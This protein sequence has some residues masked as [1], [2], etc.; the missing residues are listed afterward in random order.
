YFYA[1]SQSALFDLG[2]KILLG[3]FFG[4]ALR[5]GGSRAPWV[6]ALGLGTILEAAQ[7]LQRSHVPSTTDVLSMTVGAA[8]GA[9][10]LERYRPGTAAV[11]GPTATVSDFGH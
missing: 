2:K 1:S 4:A 11:S 7:L 8:L 5:A 6:W 3:G 9:A 10:I